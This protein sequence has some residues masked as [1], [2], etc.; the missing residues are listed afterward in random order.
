[1][2]STIA[3][4]ITVGVLAG[5][6]IWASQRFGL[7]AWGAVVSWAA[8]FAAGG[9]SAGLAKTLPAALSGV[10]WGWLAALAA[11]ALTGW[12]GA[13]AVAVG[14]AA[15]AMCAQALWR[16]LSF[17]PGT[18]LGAATLFGTGVDVPATVAVLVIG[19][20]LGLA[21]EWSADA[22]VRATARGTG[23]EPAAS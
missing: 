15:F 13:L 3:V 11:G 1:M 22:L 2:R 10:L 18:F 6:W 5:L 23:I 4:G 20:V 12:S 14:V 7:P 21:S 8:F 9:K 17:I 19:V 16:A